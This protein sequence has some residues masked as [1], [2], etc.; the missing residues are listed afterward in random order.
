MI[1]LKR[2]EEIIWSYTSMC[3][4]AQIHTNSVLQNEH[5]Y[6]PYAVLTSTSLIWRGFRFTG[7]FRTRIQVQQLH[8]CRLDTCGHM[9]GHLFHLIPPMA[10]QC[11][12]PSWQPLWGSPNIAMAYV[13]INCGEWRR[14]FYT[15]LRFAAYKTLSIEPQNEG[16]A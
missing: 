7:L 10:L 5:L 16:T 15:I 4:F 1:T 9:Y 8:T 13:H 3:D 14:L 2:F 12:R 6:V 11:A